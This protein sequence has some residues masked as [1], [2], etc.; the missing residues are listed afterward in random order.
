MEVEFG[1]ETE[2]MRSNSQEELDDEMTEPEEN[3]YIAIIEGLEYQSKVLE[4]LKN[5]VGSSHFPEKYRET[6]NELFST[7][8]LDRLQWNLTLLASEAQ[9]RILDENDMTSWPIGHLWRSNFD[10]PSY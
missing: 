3:P 2:I 4:D 1:I 5:E 7:K 6:M 9:Q 10:D 8:E